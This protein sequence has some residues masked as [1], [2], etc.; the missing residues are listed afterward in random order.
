MVQLNTAGSGQ[1]QNQDRIDELHAML[2]ALQADVAD[3]RAILQSKHKETYTVEEFADL[4]G[5]SAYT[6]RRWV[7]EKK[8]HAIRV[9]GTGPKGRLLIP[10]AE[11]KT[12]IGTANG[13]HVPGF[14]LN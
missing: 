1:N 9:A 6:I 12:L 13:E 3:V 8:I 11:V 4:V 7:K 14:A 2:K 5:R 10:H